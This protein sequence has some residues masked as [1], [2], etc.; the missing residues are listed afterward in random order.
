[1]ERRQLSGA[2]LVWPRAT[3]AQQPM[4]PV[5]RLSQQRLTRRIPAVLVGL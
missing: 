4:L 3:L 2:A 1:M 5:I